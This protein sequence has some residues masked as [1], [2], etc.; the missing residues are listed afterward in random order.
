M[1][2]RSNVRCIIYGAEDILDAFVTARRITNSDLPEWMH[3]YVSTYFIDIHRT[4]LKVYDF[5][6]ED[7]KWYGGYPD[8][9]VAEAF[10]Q[11]AREFDGLEVEFVRVGED[12]DDIDE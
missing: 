1:G 8:V 5:K 2:Y 9:D 7:V 3:E 12:M 6:I 11:A 4:L 10:F